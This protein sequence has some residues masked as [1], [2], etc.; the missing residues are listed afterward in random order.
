MSIKSFSNATTNRS[1]NIGDPLRLGYSVGEVARKLDI[2]RGHA[3]HL[4]RQGRIPS[5]KLGGRIVVP[6][7]QLEMLLRGELSETPDEK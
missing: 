6:I 5:L 7:V 3:Y 1:M 2:S 4:I